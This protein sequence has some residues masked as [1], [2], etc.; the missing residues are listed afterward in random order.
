MTDSSTRPSRPKREKPGKPYPGFP[1]YPHLS[2]KWAKT[3]RGKGYYFG[4]WKDPQG[5]LEEYEAV[6]DDLHA[7]RTPKTKGSLTLRQLC[8]E[9]I[10][11]RRV[12][13]EAGRLSPTTYG[14]YDAVCRRM[15]K[16]LG[17][18]KCVDDLGPRDFEKLYATMA[19]TH[20]LA[21]LSR[22]ITMTRSVFKW[23]MENDRIQKV[24]KFGTSFKAPNR[25]TKRK[26]RAR[27][28]RE[29]GKRLFTDD[30]IRKLIE[31]APV[32]LKAM[33]L[34]GING[35]LGNSD[36][37]NLPISALDLKNGWLSYPRP[38][39]GIER[40]IPLW[41]ETVEALQE[42]LRTRKAPHDPADANL[43]FVTRCKQKWV[44]YEVAHVK[45]RGKLTIKSKTDDAIATSF[46]K[47][48]VE[49]GMRR[50]GL[51]FYRLR[52]TFE[53]IAGGCK[54]QVAVD[55][56]MGH[57]DSSMAATYRH[58]IDDSR[59]RAVVDHVHVWLF[60]ESV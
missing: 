29:N 6:R 37:G 9:Y 46:G 12:D 3:I 11:A 43:V 5:A 51:T 49:L 21:S 39:S 18:S 58:D 16:V 38:K 25:A 28:E 15:L 32:Q 48:L 27:A 10:M 33:I 45:V 22:E 42:V 1:L 17:E 56:I 35:G 24:V 14:D 53:T 31:N 55:A 13:L 59:L 23:G 44:R 47:L 19:K 52:H 7:G 50:P 60:G 54:D 41:T 26:A 36:C 30:E 34:L 8:N 2:G 20:S 57:C 4:R 40:R